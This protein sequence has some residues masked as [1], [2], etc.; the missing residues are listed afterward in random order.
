MKM[1]S[2]LSPKKPQKRSLQ[3]KFPVKNKDSRVLMM[4]HL[5]PGIQMF[6]VFGHRFLRSA[7]CLGKKKTPI[8]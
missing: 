6:P 4:V 7:L 2:R 5:D 3:K 8:E 1:T